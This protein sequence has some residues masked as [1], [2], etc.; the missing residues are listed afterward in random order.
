MG[1]GYPPQLEG[2]KLCNVGRTCYYCSHIYKLR[3]SG[4]F[5]L[6]SLTAELGN[7]T[8]LHQQFNDLRQTMLKKMVDAGKRAILFKC[9]DDREARLQ[10][11][12]ERS[13]A[14][15]AP[16]D[17]AIP[18]QDYIA[19]WGG[20][21]RLARKVTRGLRGKASTAWW[22]REGSAGKCGGARLYGPAATRPWMRVLIS[23]T[24]A[25]LLIS[26]T[27]SKFPSTP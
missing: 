17:E 15:E 9:E 14:I 2:G 4:R 27:T 6:A 18:C 23:Y 13:T 19:E 26:C 21:R 5:T 25:S 11:S 3:Y 12:D 1:A 20:T 7:N 24:T 16:A 8:E 10:I 22:C